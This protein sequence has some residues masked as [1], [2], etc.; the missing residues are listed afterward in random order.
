MKEIIS[1]EFVVEKIKEYLS[2][3]WSVVSEK[4]LHEKGCD[5]VL[6]DELNKHK[7]RRF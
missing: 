7:A 3:R 5:L 6:R 4:D 1:E 2:S